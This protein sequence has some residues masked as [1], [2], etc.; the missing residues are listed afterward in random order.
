MLLLLLPYSGGA[1]DVLLFGLAMMTTV[2]AK[3]ATEAFS[4]HLSNEATEHDD[5]VMDQQQQ[6]PTR[7]TTFCVAEPC[8]SG[9]RF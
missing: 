9:R 4:P 8:F 6:L 3:A 7:R 2:M 5:Y 1:M